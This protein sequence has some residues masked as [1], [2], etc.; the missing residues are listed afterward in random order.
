M[1]DPEQMAQDVAYGLGIDVYLADDGTVS[2][3]PPEDK[4]SKR[5]RR[6]PGSG[7]N[8]WHGNLSPAPPPAG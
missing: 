5:I 3:H 6:P 4:P 1:R 8:I 7:M 2:Q